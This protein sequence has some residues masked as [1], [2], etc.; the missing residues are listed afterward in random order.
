M[1]FI[2]YMGK[3]VDRFSTPF[4]RRGGH[5][6]RFCPRHLYWLEKQVIFRYPMAAVTRGQGSYGGG[7]RLA[8]DPLS[9]EGEG[10]LQDLSDGLT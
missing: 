3:S 1:I 8:G 10:G 2:L 9:G 7:E 6:Q 5:I 4:F